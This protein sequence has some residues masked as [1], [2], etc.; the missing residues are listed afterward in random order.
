V[1]L[2]P[3]IFFDE[4]NERQGVFHRRA[5][6]LGGF[7]GLGALAL[8]GRLADL[9][10][11]EGARYQLLSNS[12]QFNFRIRP[13]PRGRILDRNGV[14]LASNRPDFRVL[15]RKGEAKEDVA[16]TLGRVAELIPITDQKQQSLL[17]EISYT[18][19]ATPI[20]L[21]N[22]L[23]WDDFTRINV[24]TPEL[25]GVAADMTE[26]RVYPFGGAFAHVIGYVA[27]VS[28][29]DVDREKGP[30]G[31]PDRLLLDPGFRIGKQGVEKALD[32]QLRGHPGGQKVEVD[33]MGRAVRE[34]PAGDIHA[35]PGKD[36]VLTL[37]ADIQNRALEVFGQDSGAAVMMD[38]RTG[39]VLC[40]LSAPSFDANQFVSGIPT[41]EYKAL[42]DY[43]HKP[44]INKALAGLY[45]PGSTF[46]TMVS[47]AALE[48]GVDPKRTYTCN[49]AFA[50]GNHV[51]HC[52]HHHGT[53]DMHAAIV[54]SCDVFFYQTALVV[55]PD[56]IADVAR[57]F[58]LG[59]IYDI[60][61]SGQRR[62][63]V[64]DTAWKKK[65]FAKQSPEAQ[66]W[67]PGE[68]PSMG[69]GQGY[70]DV[71]ALQL[72][73]MAARLAN[74]Q[75]A[76]NPRLIRTI[77]GVE[78]PRGSAVDDLPFTAEHIQFVRTA[79]ASVANDAGG[80]A[81]AA[82]QLG[83]GPIKMA[84][85]TGTAQSHNYVT[86]HGQHGAVG[87]W[88]TRDNAW[89][90][91]FAPYD[92]PR[93]AVSV[94]VEH[95]GFGAESAAPKAREIM[96]VALLKDPE[97]RARIEQPLPMPRMDPNALSG[98]VAPPPPTDI[99]GAAP[100]GPS[101]PQL[102]NPNTTDQPT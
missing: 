21:A 9:Q 77:G 95:G 97:V 92:D 73:V 55:G 63:I 94:L 79:M 14:E 24:R 80:T 37:D 27:R 46:K 18:P 10:L 81:F 86:G 72:C 38:V 19:K 60:G 57:K 93:Y 1:S 84:G 87:A 99:P 25:P 41:A 68:T 2:E 23:S 90:I 65:Y 78:Q 89:F 34:D 20:A 71:N 36:V 53:L 35:I 33:S 5:F 54:T 62:G 100:Q 58:G 102:Q 75:K 64:P 67:W 3:S 40:M 74:A 28:A 11:V 30:D 91:A 50:F 98:D 69:I 45:H 48:A 51:F 82:A 22:D 101:G 44:L 96:R 47:L 31:K 70:T 26:A 8:T 4:V 88:A 66:R 61:I 49:G 12:N 59:Q 6:I 29:E 13:P 42:S 15:Y 7:A 56:R 83:L 32:L 39:D 52:D 43:D 76:L 17:K 16:D 85:K